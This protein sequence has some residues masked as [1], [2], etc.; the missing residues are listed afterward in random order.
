MHTLSQL[1]S[2]ELTGIKRLALSENLTTFPLEILSLADSLEILDLSNNQLT[3]L[4]AEIAQL[5]K[6]KILFASNNLFVTLPEV[7]GQCPNLEMVGFKSNQ[8]NQVPE[9]SLPV[10][11]R[12]LILTDNRIEVLPDS[13]GERPRLQKL[14]LAGNCLT[15][16]PQTMSQCHNLELVRISANRLTACPEQLFG[17][18][19]L[20]WFAFSGNPFSQSDVCIDTVPQLVSSSYTL[21]N[22]LGQGASGVISKAVWNEQ[23]TQFPD[24][25]AVKVF[26]GEVTSDGYPEDELQA[27]LKVG[28]HP[29]LVQSLA[30]VKEDGYLA[31]IM[32]LIPAHYA[33]LGLPPCFNSCTRDTFPTDFTLS[34]T[35][36]DKIVSQMDEV[37]THL[38]DNQVCHG[39]LYA[40]NTLF[41]VDANIIFGDFGAATMYHM[42]TETQQ[43]QVKQIENR[44]LLHFIDDLLSVCAEEDKENDVFKHLKLRVG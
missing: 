22:V 11:L 21:Q 16:L 9:N 4:P 1:K 26:K 3:T 6:L 10:K 28:N 31:L 32:N 29:S 23:Q 36:I 14:A 17:L 37:F 34:I 20:A 18:P 5:T 38:H 19:K 15:E 24:E 8:I 2:G 43:A 33:N 44:A 40:H 35:Q 39:D 12:W 42:L 30:Q 25:I 7:L 13:L 27:C 41:D